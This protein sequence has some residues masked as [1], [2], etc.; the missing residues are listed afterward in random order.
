ISSLYWGFEGFQFVSL[1]ALQVG[2]PS[3]LGEQPEHKVLENL[4]LYIGQAKSLTRKHF[5]VEGELHQLQTHTRNDLRVYLRPEKTFGNSLPQVPFDRLSNSFVAVIQPLLP[6]RWMIF[7][8]IK[9]QRR[10]H[11]LDVPL[12]ASRQ[13]YQLLDRVTRFLFARRD[14]SA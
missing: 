9:Q 12:Q 1:S 8:Q 14:F 10:I 7:L 13:Q 11:I 4:H 5:F 6:S 3:L 2:L